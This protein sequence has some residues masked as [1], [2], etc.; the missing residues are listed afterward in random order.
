MINISSNYAPEDGVREIMRLI[1]SG[2]VKYVDNDIYFNEK[3]ISNLLNNG[4][5][6]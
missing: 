5:L 1:R 3:H 6:E 4:E 2:K